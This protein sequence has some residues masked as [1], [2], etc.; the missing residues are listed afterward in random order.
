MVSVLLY[1]STFSLPCP[2]TFYCQ[3]HLQKDFLSSFVFFIFHLLI[4]N[5]SLLWSCFK[6]C[7]GP[8]WPL[9]EVEQREIQSGK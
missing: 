2:S 7:V 3:V 6:F 9:V 1:S 8:T 5:K 4:W